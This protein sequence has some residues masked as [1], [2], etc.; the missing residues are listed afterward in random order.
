[1][2]LRSR[3]P[4]QRHAQRAR[5]RRGGEREHVH[6][7]A[8]RLHRFLVAHAEAVFLVD[9]EQAQARELHVAGQQLVRA[10]DDVHRAV[11]DA[12]QRRLHFLGGAEARQ[13]GH[14]HRPLAE[15]VDQGLVMLLGQQRGR[16]QDRHLLA[17]V[18]G[19]ERRAQRDLGLAEAD[20]AAHQAVHRP[21]ADHVL[22]H[23]V[24][25]GA[26]VGGFLEAE[27]GGEGLVVVRAEA[28]REAF[29]RGAAGVQVQQLGGGVAHLL[30]GLAARLLPLAAA[31]PVQ[32]R[33]FGADAGVAA[34]Q[35]QLRHRHVER[36]LVG[37]FQV[38][39]F[40]APPSPRSILTRPW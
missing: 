1:M 29:A 2:T 7:G 10:D 8:Q 19:D 12:F 11:G 15:A 34:D 20:V 40:A 35:V 4:F 32:R 6:L 36:G 38:Q 17:A 23:G 28:V 30:G 31:Q 9:D 37:V 39:E 33:L 3:R 18:H 24:D 13:L 22:D 25:G 27:A 14:L 5:D 16:R 26:L 21:R